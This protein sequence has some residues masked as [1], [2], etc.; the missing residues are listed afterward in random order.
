M[1][2]QYDWWFKMQIRKKFR[3]MNDRKFFNMKD[4]SVL[5]LTSFHI[6]WK[7]GRRIYIQYKYVTHCKKTANWN[8]CDYGYMEMKSISY[9]HSRSVKETIRIFFI[10]YMTMY[11]ICSCYSE[12]PTIGGKCLYNNRLYIVKTLLYRNNYLIFCIF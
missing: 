11:N 3:S 2:E 8:G 1:Q 6:F 10:I 7:T 9:W 12:Y 5:C 4:N